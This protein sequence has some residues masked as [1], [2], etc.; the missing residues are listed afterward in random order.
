MSRCLP[1]HVL[2]IN[3][4][5]PAWKVVYPKLFP[6]LE[7]R[8]SRRLAREQ[9]LRR[10][11]REVN[12]VGFFAA[13][14]QERIAANNKLTRG[15]FLSDEALLR[16][17]IVQ[18]LLDD[19]TPTVA[20][21]NWNEIAGAVKEVD[22]SQREAH[23]STLLRMIVSDDNPNPTE[24]DLRCATSIFKCTI[25]VK[26]DRYL[27]SPARMLW[28]PRLLEHVHYDARDDPTST[29]IYPGTQV[30]MLDALEVATDIQPLIRRLLVE[31]ALPEA[32]TLD[33]AMAFGEGCLCNRCDPRLIRALDFQGLVSP[34][35]YYHR[36]GS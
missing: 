12:V 18:T 9:R 32:A 29:G 8:R 3:S 13:Y 28:Y 30:L 1:Q 2:L 21:E 16:L 17:P 11:Q 15:M 36:L 35:S 6:I 34:I 24:G 33:S 4:K 22:S 19:D 23:L 5:Y 20:K 25:C 7:E 10:F 26:D 27:D 14:L 31:A